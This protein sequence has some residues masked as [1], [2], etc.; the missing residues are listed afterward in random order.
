MKLR[1]RVPQEPQPK[2]LDLDDA[3]ELQVLR[4]MLEE[5]SQIPAYNQVLLC[6]FPPKRLPMETDPSAPISTIFRPGDMV[7]VQAGAQTE[8]KQG[9]TDGKYIPPTFE[10]GIFVRR[11]VPADNSCLFHSLT[12]VCEG[13]KRIDPPCTALRERVAEA[14]L[15][16]KSKYTP[17]YLEQPSAEHYALWIQQ[18]TSWGGAIELDILSFLYQTEICVCDLQSGMLHRVGSGHGYSTRVFIAYTGKHYDALAVTNPMHSTSSEAAD[19]EM[20]NVTDERALSH[21]NDFIKRYKG[22]A[23]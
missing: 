12:Y 16:H 10:R 18:P 6:G 21:A 2:E 17:E 13:K 20:F 3:T 4:M 9:H 15:L 7:I 11:N 14:V 19:Q 22:Q 5:V 1:F 8:V 23:S